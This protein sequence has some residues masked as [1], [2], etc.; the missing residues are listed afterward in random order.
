MKETITRS[1][2][3]VLFVGVII[4]SL[5]VHPYFYLALFSLICIRGW[6]E[7]TGL[8]PVAGKN[9]HKITEALLLTGTFIA[10]FF[11]LNG[12]L[13]PNFLLIAAFALILMISVII[14]DI[15]YAFLDPRIRL[16]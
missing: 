16:G 2:T 10:V 9:R 7:F 13:S 15:S 5:I 11:M 8:F 1:L 12:Q 14:I 6:F 4:S 3:G